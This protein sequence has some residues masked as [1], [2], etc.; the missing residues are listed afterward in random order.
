MRFAGRRAPWYRRRMRIELG[1]GFALRDW[2]AAWANGDQERFLVLADDHDVWVNLRDHFPHP[3]TRAAAEAWVSL[4]AG[5]DPPVCFAICDGA[6][7]IGSIDLRVGE[8]DLRHSAEIGYWL[9]KP[10]WGRGIV[11]AAV[12]AVT[13]YGFE[14]FGLIRVAAWLKTGNSASARV[15]EKAGYEREGLLRRAVLKAGVPMDY[16]LYAIL[17]ED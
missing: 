1:N 8:G 3:Y 11:T 2:G 6:G 12:R 15:L 17:R 16:L 9:G 7:P 14:T 13:A 10:F 5:R 4:Q